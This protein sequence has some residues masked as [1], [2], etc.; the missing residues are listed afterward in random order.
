MERKTLAEFGTSVREWGKYTLLSKSAIGRAGR[1][2]TSIMH[3]LNIEVITEDREPKPG[4][5]KV[6]DVF[7][8]HAACGTRSNGQ[9]QAIPV[10]GCETKDVT[11]ERCMKRL[12]WVSNDGWRDAERDHPQYRDNLNHAHQESKPCYQGCPL[13]SLT[14][15]S[16]A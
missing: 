2:G 3:M 8:A 4:T 12:G 5:M 7:C 14:R 15:M 1:R 10:A 13:W 6:G 11:C 9:H 16:L